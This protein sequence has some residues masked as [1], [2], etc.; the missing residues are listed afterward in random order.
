MVCGV[1]L[2]ESID[3]TTMFAALAMFVQP[4]C[5][6]CMHPKMQGWSIE[7][8]VS[9]QGYLS[10]WYVPYVPFLMFLCTVFFSSINLFINACLVCRLSSNSD[11]RFHVMFILYPTAILLPVM[12]LVMVMFMERPFAYVFSSAIADIP[13]H[14][15][16]AS[17]D[18]YALKAISI[19]CYVILLVLAK[20]S[21]HLHRTNYLCTMIPLLYANQL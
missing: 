12:H 15:L 13:V 21:I 5:H 14:M 1:F 18:R 19:L 11:Q 16:C 9:L 3:F 6:L 7:A 2:F 8:K 17:N 20:S 10:S 4:C